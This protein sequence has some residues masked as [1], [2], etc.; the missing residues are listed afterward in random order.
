MDRPI[1]SK[2]KFDPKNPKNCAIFVRLSAIIS[3]GNKLLKT[4]TPGPDVVTHF[5]M[6]VKEEGQH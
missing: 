5:Y 6:P 1:I 2:N 4:G 3:G